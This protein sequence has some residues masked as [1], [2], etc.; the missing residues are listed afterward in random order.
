MWKG[1]RVEI[2]KTKEGGRGYEGKTILADLDLRSLLGKK[3]TPSPFR[4]KKKRWKPESFRRG[5][6]RKREEKNLARASLNIS[7]IGRKG[8]KYTTTP[9]LG[10][11]V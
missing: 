4:I 8:G 6:K 7:W 10:R 9:Q 2:C 1:E 3:K 5:K 11:E